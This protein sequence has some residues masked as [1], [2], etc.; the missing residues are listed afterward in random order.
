MHSK[1]ERKANY[2][3]LPEVKQANGRKKFTDKQVI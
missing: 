1:K 2:A 3:K